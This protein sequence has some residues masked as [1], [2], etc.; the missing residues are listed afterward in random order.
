VFKLPVFTEV[1]EVAAKAGCVVVAANAS[2]NK[3]ANTKLRIA[4][5]LF[6]SLQIIATC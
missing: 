3:A 5:K 4:A 6:I 2:A 1:P